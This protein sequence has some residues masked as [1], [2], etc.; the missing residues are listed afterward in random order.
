MV[1]NKTRK[2]LRKQNKKQSIRKTK[3][4]YGGASATQKGIAVTL[5]DILKHTQ[6]AFKDSP[7]GKDMFRRLNQIIHNDDPYGK[8]AREASLGDLDIFSPDPNAQMLRIANFILSSDFDNV[9]VEIVTDSDTLNGNIKLSLDV[10]KRIVSEI[11]KSLHNDVLTDN[12]AIMRLFEKNEEMSK[13][14]ERLTQTNTALTGSSESQRKL[15]SIIEDRN[16]QIQALE[17]SIKIK[18]QSSKDKILNLKRELEK[19]QALKTNEE[20]R[21]SPAQFEKGPA[22]FEKEGEV[23][24]IG[25]T[26]PAQFEKAGTEFGEVE[27]IGRTSPAQFEKAGTEFGEVEQ[28]EK[29]PVLG[30]NVTALKEQPLE[31]KIDQSTGKRLPEREGLAEFAREFGIPQCEDF[32]K[33]LYDYFKSFTGEPNN[34]L[35]ISIVKKYI[36]YIKNCALNSKVFGLSIQSIGSQRPTSIKDLTK[37]VSSVYFIYDVK[38]K[39]ETFI[40]EHTFN[41]IVS[42]VL[43]EDINSNIFDIFVYFV[44]LNNAFSDVYNNSEYGKYLVYVKYIMDKE[45]FKSIKEWYLNQPNITENL[46]KTLKQYAKKMEKADPEIL[47]KVDITHFTDVIS[48]SNEYVE[49]S[50]E[51]YH[52]INALSEKTGLAN[53]SNIKKYDSAKLEEETNAIESISD[54]LLSKVSI[55]SLFLCG[56]KLNIGDFVKYNSMQLCKIVSIN[57]D[58]TYNI[59]LITGSSLEEILNNVP[60]S[61]IRKNNFNMFAQLR[62]NFDL[63]IKV[64]ENNKNYQ[65]KIRFIIDSFDRII[66]FVEIADTILVEEVTTVPQQK[67]AVP[68]EAAA[69]SKKFTPTVS[70]EEEESIRSTLISNGIN[71]QGVFGKTMYDNPL[72]SGTRLDDKA[73]KAYLTRTILENYTEDYKG[74]LKMQFE[75]Y[76]VPLDEMI[77]CKTQLDQLSKDQKKKIA[78]VKTY[79]NFFRDV[80]DNINKLFNIFRKTVIETGSTYT[81]L[82]ILIYIILPPDSLVVHNI[83]KKYN[84]LERLFVSNPSESVKMPNKCEILEDLANYIK[85]YIIR[86]DYINNVLDEIR[87]KLDE[88]SLKILKITQENKANGTTNVVNDQIDFTILTESLFP[89]LTVFTFGCGYDDALKAKL[90]TVLKKLISLEKYDETN[91]IINESLLPLSKLFQKIKNYVDTIKEISAS[92]VAKTGMGS[93]LNLGNLGRKGGKTKKK[94][95]FKKQS[96]NKKRS[97]GK[98]RK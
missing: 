4:M 13:E 44:L 42:Y 6:Q 37:C 77:S 86:K 95:N 18:D 78:L 65:N 96:L 41:N 24:Q 20:G 71:N 15:T 11:I 49:F 87:S 74:K 38:M 76:I 17:A 16:K 43:K 60:A 32:S 12:I 73:T 94:M 93:V 9:H 40:I 68:Q 67:S 89:V 56:K 70:P 2:I 92:E 26:S 8:E 22:S 21:T 19:Y 62:K 61:A 63:M 14:I 83:L 59:L 10:A 53:I 23:E 66:R 48:Y 36:S 1:K 29:P 80:N 54:R 27:Q 34:I 7:E 57:S 47:Q 81:Y 64:Q 84:T 46:L 55:L 85:L 88:N 72:L 98:T 35:Y 45:S 69:V 3:K 30:E 50:D 90:D 82:S 97:R 31:L 52:I 33:I 79:N 28:F 58:G 5:R 51:F 91:N 39:Y 75:K 25:R